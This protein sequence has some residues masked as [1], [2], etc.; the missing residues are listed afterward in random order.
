[1]FKLHAAVF[2]VI[3]AVGVSSASLAAEDNWRVS[4]RADDGFGWYSS[5]DGQFGAYPGCLDGVGD[6]Q[7]LSAPYMTDLPQMCRWIVSLSPGD[8]RTWLR[9]IRSPA[10]PASYPGQIRTWDL[11]IAGMPNATPDPMRLF[12]CTRGSGAL[13]PAAISGVEVGYRL[14]MVDNRGV[15]GAP[16]N[17]RVWDLPIPASH[18]SQPYW[19]MPEADWL[20]MLRVSSPTHEAMIAEGYVMRFE[21]YVLPG[22]YPVPEPAAMP[23]LGIGLAGIAAS[24]LRRRRA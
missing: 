23:A 9:D 17:L 1:M 5:A 16:A 3:L 2:L 19:Y 21:Q 11:R 14:V 22:Q 15:P 10:S 20:P 18:A 4:V 7:D 6:A 13:P 24:A 8:P 12:L